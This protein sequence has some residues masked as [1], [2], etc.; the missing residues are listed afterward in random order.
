MADTREPDVVTRSRT[1]QMG[2]WWWQATGSPGVADTVESAFE[3]GLR[4]GM[5]RCVDGLACTEEQAERTVRLVSELLDHGRR[6]NGRS[7]SP[8]GAALFVEVITVGTYARVVNQE[9]PL[10][11]ADVERYAGWT[12]EMSN[13]WFHL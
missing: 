6:L 8:R 1:F 11:D 9:A 10:T 3:S 13:S 4:H 2:S 12:E 7:W 5:R